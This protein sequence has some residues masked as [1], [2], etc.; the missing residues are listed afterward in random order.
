[1]DIYY[2]G[3]LTKKQYRTWDRGFQD[4]KQIIGN[5]QSEFIFDKQGL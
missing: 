4:G 2:T 5:T 1:M 3:Y